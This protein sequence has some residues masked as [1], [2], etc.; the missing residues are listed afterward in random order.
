MRPDT[1]KLLEWIKPSPPTDD[2]LECM[3]LLQPGDYE[4]YTE[5]LN[6]FLL[7]SKEVFIKLGVTSM[8]RSGDLVTGIYTPKGDMVTAWCGTYL[9]AVVGQLPIKFVAETWVNEP[10]VGV[11]DGDIFY[12]SDPL[13]GG[14]HNCD[15][16]LVMPVFNDDELIGWTNAAVHEPETGATVP[17]GA[18]FNAKTRH[19]EGMLLSP[20]KIGENFRFREDLV[21]MCVNLISR[22]PRMQAVDMKARLSAADRLRER[23]V[24]L[25][26]EKGNDFVK[27]LF[28]RIVIEAEEGTRRRIREWND[29]TY[30]AVNFMDMVGTQ[31]KLVRNFL[32]LHK[33]GDRLI[34]DFTGTS[35]E[36]DCSQHSMPHS[37]AANIALHLMAYSFH[38]LPV[39]AGVFAPMEWIVPEGCMFNPHPE[40]AQSHC[41][42]A[43]HGAMTLGAVCMSKL[44]FDSPQQELVAAPISNTGTG[45][46]LSGENQW[47]VL[48]ADLIA[49]AMNTEGHGARSDMDGVDAFGFSHCYSGRAPDIEDIETEF[50]IF[51]LLAKFHKDSCGF[52]KYR[53]GSGTE[54]VHVINYVD[55]ALFASNVKGSKIR[56]CIG[57]FGGYPPATLPGVEV[58]HTNL[59]EKMKRGDRDLPSDVMGLISERTIKGEYDMGS[60]VKE[61]HL[62]AN[63]DL[64]SVSNGGGGGYGDV[65][66]RDPE[67]VMDDVRNEIISHRTAEKVY[68]VAYNHET[69][70]VDYDRTNELRQ[71]ERE[72]RKARG[73]SWVEF[74]KEWSQLRPTEEAMD[75]YGSWPDGK[76]TREIIRM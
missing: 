56:N 18:P 31:Q 30:R 46:V 4:I 53:G 41:A 16:I 2:E 59:W 37:L 55:R 61:M 43:C 49:L 64:W 5:K 51:N 58:H 20:I 22:A 69:L 23:V 34:W 47:G 11:K 7:E 73:L 66:E 35:P 45:V 57:L 33:K 68:Q 75:F 63:G 17:G 40:A 70:E 38:D 25:A 3:K 27:G 24:S 32:T 67:M 1:Q 72:D 71:K 36:N 76:K 28:R 19:D 54:I 9:H 50:Q 44:M 42:P 48:V 13:Y 26:Q 39:S 8:L 74:E 65:L 21:E 29:G 14:I 62:T 10:T 52:G 60:M 12:A 6:N 15:Q